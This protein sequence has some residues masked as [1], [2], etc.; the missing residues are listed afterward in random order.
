[1]NK[2]G[3]QGS[4]GAPERPPPIGL[5]ADSLITNYELGVWERLAD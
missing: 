2:T 4:I 5:I 1:M 3:A